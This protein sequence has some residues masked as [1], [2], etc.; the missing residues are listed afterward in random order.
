MKKIILIFSIF[1]IGCNQKHNDIENIEILTYG[2]NHDSDSNP[3]MEHPRNYSIIYG[4]GQSESINYL[5]DL[6][7]KPKFIKH[8]INEKI[9]IDISKKTLN[10]DDK[11]F[12]LK[13]N[14]FTNEIYCGL[15]IYTRVRIKYNDR[16]SITF[17]YLNH[18]L[19]TKRYLEFQKLE[20][21]FENSK[22]ITKVVN[23]DTLN[24]IKSMKEFES[25]SKKFEKDLQFPRV[26]NKVKLI[27]SKS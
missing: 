7:N 19:K 20:R 26:I 17:V 22:I 12:L 1:T 5:S 10:L 21:Q 9:L 13:Q 11:Y 4:N 2:M 15:T 6:N 23:N 25:F 8:T 3:V 27:E 24:L 16:K 14:D 18:N